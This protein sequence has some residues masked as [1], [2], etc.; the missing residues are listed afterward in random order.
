MERYNVL[1]DR[2]KKARQRTGL[3]QA[4]LAKQLNCTQAALSQYE[5]GNREPGLEDL[6]NI[7]SKLN[8][9]TDYLLGRTDIFSEDVS[10]KNIGNY[11]GLSYEA[12]E[13]LHEK[14]IQRKRKTAENYILKEVESWIGLDTD[15]E[16]FARYY[17]W[18]KKDLQQD[19]EDYKKTL[20]QFICSCEFSELLSALIN[21]IYLERS[22][23]DLLRIATNR[24]DELES[25]SPSENIA[26]LAYSLA[27]RGEDNIK[28]YLLNVF[29]IQNSIT[30]FCQ[31]FTK[32]EGIKRAEHKDAFY[33]LVVFYVH[34]ATHDMF[35]NESFSIEEMEEKLGRLKDNYGNQIEG[36][37]KK[38]K[39]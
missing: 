37:L 1:G 26:E 5:T 38:Y 23:Y 27:E 18:I 16:E 13:C 7:A 32:L 15:E 9:S 2:I 24:Y 12:I 36:F 19:L 3:K 11:L 31:N 14:Y 34:S 10:I 25:C 21:N 8:T 6:V 17:N 39:V 4:D 28:Q 22:V 20:N 33:K 30:D 29:E 35:K